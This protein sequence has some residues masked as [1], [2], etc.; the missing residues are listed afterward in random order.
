MLWVRDYHRIA[1][2]LVRMEEFIGKGDKVTVSGGHGEDGSL[3]CTAQFNA[4]LH[5]EVEHLRRDDDAGR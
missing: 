5:S 3:Q 1:C 2:N 4:L